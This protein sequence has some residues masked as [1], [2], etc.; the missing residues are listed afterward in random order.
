MAITFH[1]LKLCLHHA[2]LPFSCLRKAQRSLEGRNGVAWANP[3]PLSLSKQIEPPEVVSV[4][5]F[6]I[7]Y[8][9]CILS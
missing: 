2:H 9:P 1:I 8:L 6:K 7:P 4:S 3:L 5:G